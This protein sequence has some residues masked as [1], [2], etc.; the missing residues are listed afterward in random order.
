MVNKVKIKDLIAFAVFIVI[1]LILS[2]I[3]YK[4]VPLA[5]VGFMSYLGLKNWKNAKNKIFILCFTI[6][7]DVIFITIIFLNYFFW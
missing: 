4:L 6:I 2:K 5:L 1:T 7:S 3:H